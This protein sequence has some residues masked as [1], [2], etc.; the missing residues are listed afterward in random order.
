M[1]LEFSGFIHMYE[2]LL[3]VDDTFARRQ[4]YLA[5]SLPFEFLPYIRTFCTF[6]AEAYPTM[7]LYFAFVNF[8]WLVIVLK[9]E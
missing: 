5:T 3:P 4:I 7:V 2:I 9:L 6:T 8:D 1:Y